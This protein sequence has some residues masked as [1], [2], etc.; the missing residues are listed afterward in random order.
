[1]MKWT[2][3]NLE[4][5]SLPKQAQLEPPNFAHEWIEYEHTSTSEVIER[6]QEADVLVINKIIINENILAHLPK[7]KLIAITASGKDN[8]DEKACQAVGVTVRNVVNYAQNTVAEHTLM[9]MLML[10]RNV[11]AYQ[12]EVVNGAWQ[13][14]AIFC[15]L[16]HAVADL[17]GKQVCLFG[18][19]AIGLRVARL[20]EAFGAQVAFI[21]HQAKLNQT[22][23][24]EGYAEWQ[25][26]L[27]S[28]DIVSL[29][30]PSTSHNKHFVNS[31]LLS[32]LKPSCLLINT[33]RGNLLNEAD[34]VDAIEQQR[35]GGI[36]V[37]VVD[38]EPIRS[39]NPLQHIVH[40]PNVI[41]TPHCSWLG[42]AAIQ[43][44]CRQTTNNINQF[45]QHWQA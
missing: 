8:V 26:G 1:M 18:R 14:S 6:A 5:R 27:Q 3:V 23:S 19:G 32:L 24:R 34:V 21:D 11:Q 33:A 13:Q 40:L 29:H 20:C 43:E 31:S 4:S 39:D 9:L 10:L 28:A 45:Y 12:A 35:L 37:D 41:I 17:Q 42:Q 16:N 15:L 25:Q 2:I 38:G 22:T 44:L 36:A 30:C 7:L